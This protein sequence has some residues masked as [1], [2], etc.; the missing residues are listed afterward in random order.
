MRLSFEKGP[1][2]RF[3]SHLDTHRTFARALRRAGLPVAFTRG[4]NPHP[5]IA[6]AQPLAV[7]ATSSS[8]ILDVELESRI[9]PAELL[10]RL[11]SSLPGG[12]EVTGAK[13]IPQDAP[14]AMSE[15]AA[16]E[17]EARAPITGGGD[18]Q[19][20]AL[21][22]LGSPVVIVPARGGDDRR[23]PRDIRPLVLRLS[24]K[25]EKDAAAFEMLLRSGGGRSV[26]PDE[27]LLAVDRMGDGWLDLDAAV[28]HRRRLYR[29][30]DSGLEP[31][32]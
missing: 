14:S 12:F 4:F 1:E 19:G 18:P 16:S 31:L 20:A 22:L 17:Y 6:F 11:N 24:G 5:K 9:D 29:A 28:Y 2:V 15:V 25:R 10:R 21:R 8:D 30:S 23:G 3:I 13:E 27:V 32:D 26:R 7:G